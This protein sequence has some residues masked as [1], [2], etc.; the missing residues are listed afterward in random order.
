[1][2][3]KIKK[4]NHFLNLLEDSELAQGYFLGKDVGE[5]NNSRLNEL[6]DMLRKAKRRYSRMSSVLSITHFFKVEN[7]INIASKVEASHRELD[8][9]VHELEIFES[10]LAYLIISETITVDDCCKKN[11]LDSVYLRNLLEKYKKQVARPFLEYDYHENTGQVSEILENGKC[12][13]L[14]YIP[15]AVKDIINQERKKQNMQDKLT[16][17]L[18][19]LE[20]E[21]LNKINMKIQ[22]FNSD[23]GDQGFVYKKRM[24]H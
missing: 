2:Y 24:K 12:I 23:D 21:L 8:G 4:H 11:D 16:Q 17:Q 19:S 6:Q 10:N 13:V 18:N 20:D 9:I 22:S 5:F 15:S 7:R 14:P 1:M 3:I